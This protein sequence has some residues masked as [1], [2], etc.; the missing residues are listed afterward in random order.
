MYIPKLKYV[1]LKRLKQLQRNHSSKQYQDWREAVLT[2]DEYT[3][4]YPGCNSD[5]NLQIHH[6]KKYSNSI[7]LRHA[8]FNG[9]TLCA[10]HHRLVTGREEAYETLFFKIVGINEHKYDDTM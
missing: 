6:I 5:K 2:R 4:Q 1:S 10:D 9:I 3:C 7:H 8:V